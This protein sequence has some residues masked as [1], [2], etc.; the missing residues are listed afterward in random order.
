MMPAVNKN[1]GT[2]KV[3]VD[4]I[5]RM[6]ILYTQSNFKQLFTDLIART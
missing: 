1:V 2:A 4:D 5:L 3:T 6:Q